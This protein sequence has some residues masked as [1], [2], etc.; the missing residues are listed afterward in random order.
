MK[1]KNLVEWILFGAFTV[2]GIGFM[3]GGIIWYC[4]LKEKEHSWVLTKAEIIDIQKS[5]H[6]G[7]EHH[8]MVLVQFLV[9]EKVY[10]TNLPEYNSSMKIGDTVSIYYNPNNPLEII[11]NSFLGYLIFICMGI[12]FAVIGFIPLFL[13]LARKHKKN[14]LMKNGKRI[15][16]TI[17]NVSFKMNYSVNGKHPYVLECSYVEPITGSVYFFTS[18]SIWY[19]IEVILEKHNITTVP[20][21]IDLKNSKKYYVDITAFKKYLGN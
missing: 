15:E 10:E 17:D 6:Y 1:N 13:M 8:Y 11:G 2:I 19:P 14:Y 5:N 21:Y 4:V 16:A 12:V 20:V 7:S 3:I 18:N 9:K